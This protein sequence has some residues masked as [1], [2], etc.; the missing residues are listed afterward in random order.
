MNQ[1]NCKINWILW[2]HFFKPTDM[3][4][5][6]NNVCI[7][8]KN[9]WRH[10]HDPIVSN[11]Q[12]PAILTVF[13]TVQKIPTFL[14]KANKRRINV[15]KTYDHSFTS[16]P[17]LHHS[18]QSGFWPIIIRSTDIFIT[19]LISCKDPVYIVQIFRQRIKVFGMEIFSWDIELIQNSRKKIL[20]I[21]PF[22]LT[23]F[24]LQVRW[25]L[26]RGPKGIEPWS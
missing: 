19:E 5:Y 13:R 1:M 21:V 26:Q 12:W 23:P 14:R 15:S 10:M 22:S 16:W 20:H 9:K 11:S 25:F 8:S 24:Y 7:G 2:S 6:L 18:V 4:C 17:W 3:N